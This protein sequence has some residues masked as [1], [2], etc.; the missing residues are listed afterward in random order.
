MEGKIFEP[1]SPCEVTCCTP[2]SN[3]SRQPLC[4]RMA[5]Y[6]AANCLTLVAKLQ[7]IRSVLA[8]LE[9]AKAEEGNA[10]C[11]SLVCD[12]C[13]LKTEKFDILW[14]VCS[15]FVRCLCDCK[16]QNPKLVLCC[17]SWCWKGLKEKCHFV[18]RVGEVAPRA[19][20]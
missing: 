8:M 5:H 4:L 9:T 11:D 12:L 6:Q 15:A 1:Q 10:F 7:F 14:Q 19:R 16:R 2:S 18:S 20:K 13:Q 3:E 17:H